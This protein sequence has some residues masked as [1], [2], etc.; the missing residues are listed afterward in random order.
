MARE[1]PTASN[2]EPPALTVLDG[3]RPHAD[4]SLLTRS[5]EHA[6]RRCESLTHAQLKKHLEPLAEPRLRTN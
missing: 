3:G 4:L 2:V 1:R 6:L 5:Q